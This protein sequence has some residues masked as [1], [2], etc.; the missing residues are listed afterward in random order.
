MSGLSFLD[1]LGILQS[2]SSGECKGQTQQLNQMFSGN[3][4]STTDL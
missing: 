2:P 4:D 1:D 3:S